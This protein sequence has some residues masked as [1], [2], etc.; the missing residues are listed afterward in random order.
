MIIMIIFVFLILVSFSAVIGPDV[1]V[2]NIF[3]HLVAVLASIVLA[4]FFGKPSSLSFS[5]N[6]RYITS[7]L[8]I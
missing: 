3:F 2:L 1:R 5:A 4:L 7:I 8:T 6:I